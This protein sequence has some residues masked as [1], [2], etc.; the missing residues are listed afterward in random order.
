[1]AA[2]SWRRT[3]EASLGLK[4]GTK[5]LQD[6]SNTAQSGRSAAPDPARRAS[7]MHA[8]LQLPI[9]PVLSVFKKPY[10]LAQF[11]PLAAQPSGT[12]RKRPSDVQEVGPYRCGSTHSWGA[13]PR[14]HAYADVRNDQPKP[15]FCVKTLA[16][17]DPRSGPKT[18]VSV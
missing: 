5:L 16:R 17:S 12:R 1:M 7:F 4:L 6:P 2:K 8:P 13:R 10:Q 14:T 9:C 18:V 15:C 11:R 3:R